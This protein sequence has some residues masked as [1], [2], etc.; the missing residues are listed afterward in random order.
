VQEF[1]ASSRRES[2]DQAHGREHVRRM[3]APPGGRELSPG[4]LRKEGPDLELPVA[5]GD[6]N[7]I[8]P[9][10]PV[11]RSIKPGSRGPP[12]SRSGR[13]RAARTFPCRRG[14]SSVPPGS[15]VQSRRRTGGSAP[16][17]VAGLSIHT[18]REPSSERV[19]ASDSA[20]AN[21]PSWSQ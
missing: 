16:A 10:N 1:G 13:H 5:M 8:V 12:R 4:N 21:R 14:R 19:S 17:T 6:P 9:P 15:A 20:I 18:S 11:G 3:A 2:L 7:S